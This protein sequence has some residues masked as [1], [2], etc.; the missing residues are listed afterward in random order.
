MVGTF[1]PDLII[2]LMQDSWCYEIA[3]R[4][5]RKM[6]IPLLLFIHDLPTG[7]EPV[8]VCLHRRQMV[9]DRRIYSQAATRFCV[10]PGMASWFEK[11]FGLRGDVLLPPRSKGLKPWNAEKCFEL[12]TPG[13]LTLGYA[14]GLH[15]GYGEQIA[16]M[17]PV[18]RETKCKLELFSP[19]PSG[20]LSSLNDAR[21]V[22]NFHGY[23]PTPEDAWIKLQTL[24]DALL[25][26]YLNPPGKHHLQYQT[27]F[28]SKLGDML[29]VGLP[30]LVTG[31]EDASGLLW[32]A[33]NGNVALTF[34]GSSVSELRDTLFRLRDDGALRVRQASLGSVAGASAF[35]PE[36]LKAKLIETMIKVTSQN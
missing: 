11:M 7:F 34:H 14:G 30:L 8:H 20:Q 13:Q 16:A 10:S 1:A 23:A 28:P 22:I 17:I 27:H 5:A 15:Y 21:D 2:T 9:R 29:S 19:K 35:S 3:A 36:K 26:P 24:C 32:C 33:N 18:L 31:P 4:Y 25:L 6:R 12:K